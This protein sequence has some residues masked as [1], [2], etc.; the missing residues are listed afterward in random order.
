MEDQK[1]KFIQDNQTRF[2]CDTYERVGAAMRAGELADVGRPIR[3][4]S[5]YVGGPRYLHQLF[6]D[7]MAIMCKLGQPSLFITMTCN[8]KWPEITAGLL[9]GQVPSDRPD[10]VA[11]V[12]NMKKK[13]LLQDITERQVFGK[14]I[15]HVSAIEFQKRG[16]PHVHLVVILHKDDKP[17]T[18]DDYNAIISAELPD[19]GKNPALHKLVMAHM[20]HGPCGAAR[21]TSPCM[22]N[23]QCTKDYP[24]K[25]RPITIVA[26]DGRPAYRR[27][28]RADGG[29]VATLLLRNKEYEITNQM[30]VPHN[31][32][33]LYKY[34]CHINVKSRDQ[35]Y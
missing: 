19:I 27:R 24:K 28:T 35:P 29:H 8:P 14:V 11:R 31:V 13:Q 6:Q 20:I 21:R 9:P 2:R 10:I 12:F 22:K 30:I 18:A 17:E 15:A 4:I 23:D 16:L 34:A 26:Q 1:L 32:Y 3:L 5:T 33:L 7:S 25:F